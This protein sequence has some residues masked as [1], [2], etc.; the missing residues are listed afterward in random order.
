MLDD[1]EVYA[2]ELRHDYA[3][4]ARGEYQHLNADTHEE[5]PATPTKKAKLAQETSPQKT[6]GQV[7]KGITDKDRRHRGGETSTSRSTSTQPLFGRGDKRGKDYERGEQ[8]RR[9]DSTRTSDNVWAS[10]HD[11]IYT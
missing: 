1:L 9:S 4:K 3:D 10:A 2:G 7:R 8:Q 6:K 11:L 5:H